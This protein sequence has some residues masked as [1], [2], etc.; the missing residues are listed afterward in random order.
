MRATRARV[1]RGH[2]V[3]TGRVSYGY[4]WA[5]AAKTTLAPNPITAPVMTRMFTDY[6]SGMT[7]RQLAAALTADGVPTPTGKT[8]I[9]DPSVIRNL[10]S[11]SLY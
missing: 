2:P 4:A 3:A 5:D 1:D 6:A 9:W 8:P 10:L 11:T 7:L